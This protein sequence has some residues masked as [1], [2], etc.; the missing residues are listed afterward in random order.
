MDQLELQEDVQRFYSRF[1]ERVVQAYYDQGMRNDVKQGENSL[2]EYLLYES[3]A[4]KIA[5]GPYPEVNILDMLV[6]IKL[7][8]VV[9]RD[10]WIPKVYG[11]AGNKLWKAFQVS[12]KDIETVAKKIM[13]D[14]DLEKI[15]NLV[16]Q[17]FKD[18]PGQF[19]VEKIRLGDFSNIASASSQG[20]GGFLDSLSISNLLVGTKGAVKAA[21]QMVLVANRGIF[22]AQH[23]PGILRLQT[24]LGTNEVMDDVS[25]RMAKSQGMWDQLNETQPIISD[26]AGLIQQMNQLV[27]NSKELAKSLPKG[28]SG[29]G[30]NWTENLK[31]LN[32]MVNTLNS[33]L[34]QINTNQPQRAQM[35]QEIKEEFRA[36]VWFLAIVIVLIGLCISIFW[37]GGAYLVK[38]REKL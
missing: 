12:E 14:K 10:F 20:P 29:Q 19:R 34:T 38:K 13:K 22:L 8:K 16:K 28:P 1:V 4:L 37:W 18:N 21:D 24:R 11:R 30:I 26:F 7:N 2:R 31:E 35:M 17:W 25:M 36:S 6:F 15:D 3:E 32:S 9:V 33:M 23:L 27:Q 5:T